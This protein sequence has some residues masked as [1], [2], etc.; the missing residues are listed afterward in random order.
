M[1]LS[2]L[3]VEAEEMMVGVKKN[4]RKE[5]ALYICSQEAHKKKPYSRTRPAPMKGNRNNFVLRDLAPTTVW[6]ESTMQSHND[7][8]VQY[9][10]KNSL[11]KPFTN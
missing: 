9:R 5:E 6:G 10:K 7:T 8:T 3:A 4:D 2:V 1:L 11:D